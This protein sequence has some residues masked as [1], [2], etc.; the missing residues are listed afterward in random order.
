MT[1]VFDKERKVVKCPKCGEIVDITTHSMVQQMSV[2]NQYLKEAI[3]FQRTGTSKAIK[4]EIANRQA[5]HL[6][7]RR[8]LDIMTPEQREQAKS[9]SQWLRDVLSHIE[10]DRK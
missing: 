4:R 2:Q 10:N 9:V 5:F 3:K 7:I 8:L 1:N 6:A